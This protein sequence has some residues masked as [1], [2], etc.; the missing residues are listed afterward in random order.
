MA[1]DGGRAMAVPGFAVEKRDGSMT[2]I[3]VA[4]SA[5]QGFRTTWVAERAAEFGKK[6]PAIVSSYAERL[7]AG[8]P[9]FDASS[10]KLLT[11]DTILKTWAAAQAKD[12]K[13]RMTDWL[14]EK[15]Q[16]GAALLDCLKALFAIERPWYRLVEMAAW[17]AAGSVTGTLKDG[18]SMETYFKSFSMEAPALAERMSYVRRAL[19]LF[20][21]ASGDSPLGQFLAAKADSLGSG[22]LF[23]GE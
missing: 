2:A 11:L 18:R 22:A 14:P 9:S 4:V 12:Y 23:F 8:R 19:H 21:Y 6:A 20:K 13:V 15:K 10:A 1:D 16:V 5:L 3:T 7:A 17:N